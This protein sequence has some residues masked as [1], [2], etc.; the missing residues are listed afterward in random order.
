MIQIHFQTK[1]LE[2]CA[3]N[4]SIPGSRWLRALSASPPFEW[5]AP[6]MPW[7]K[8]LFLLSWFLH[9]NFISAF[10]FVWNALGLEGKI[11]SPQIF[12]AGFWSHRL[13]ISKI[14]FQQI[15][16]AE[17]WSHS[18]N[19]S[20]ILFK[21]IYFAGFSS[22]SSNISKILSQQIF[23]RE[24]GHTAQIFLNII[25]ANISAE[26]DNTAHLALLSLLGHR[27]L[28]RLFHLVGDHDDRDGHE[29]VIQDSFFNCS[30][31][32]SSKC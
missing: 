22:H 5:K 18:S 29:N 1:Q 2:K 25:S 10:L 15:F 12:F 7:A 20:K 3:R 24:I 8:V 14:V 13:N 26:I 4:L 27:L 21:Q 17:F 28:I 23:L 11:S 30:S 19:I 6:F 9:L 32:K 16:F 31:P